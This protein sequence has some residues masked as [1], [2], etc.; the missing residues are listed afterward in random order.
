MHS[1]VSV[2]SVMPIIDSILQNKNLCSFIGVSGVLIAWVELMKFIANKGYL[3]A[4][5]RRKLMHC[6]T[7]PIFLLFWPFFSSDQVG[8][9]YATAVPAIM[10]FKFALVGLGFLR[11][12]D[13]VKS[14]SRIGDRT[15]LLRGPLLYGLVFIFSTSLFWK[16]TTGIIGF[17][18]L[19]FGDGFAEIV[20]RLYGGNN[21][22]FWSKDKSLA[23]MIG[24]VIA[25]SLSVL[26]FLF[27][28][29][30][31]VTST[32]TGSLIG[33]VIAVNMVAALVE[34]LP[35]GEIDNIT[36]FA[37]ASIADKVIVNKGLF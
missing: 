24:F 28:Y 8:S 36:V 23:G 9:Y 33:R 12:D 11:D 2:R 30:Q 22:L 18:A 4:W 20:G 15:E 19:C 37:A 5:A 29:P 35:I 21:K 32:P 34:T 13:A 6:L 26:L 31:V 10:T 1:V 3:T 25:S 14:M 27:L 17:F 16:D 7:G